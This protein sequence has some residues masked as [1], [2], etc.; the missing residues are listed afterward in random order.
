MTHE[1]LISLAPAAKHAL[2]TTLKIHRCNSV[3]MRW[4]VAPSRDRQVK[5]IK[6]QSLTLRDHFQVDIVL[7]ERREHFASYTNHVLHIGAH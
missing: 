5:P 2:V 3:N 7:T 4:S 1:M 6:G